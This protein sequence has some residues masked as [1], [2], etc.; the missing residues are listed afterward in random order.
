MRTD[1]LKISF[2]C[3]RENYIIAKFHQGIASEE[4][5]TEAKMLRTKID[6]AIINNLVGT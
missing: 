4:E 2:W 3:I 1:P 6:D 5:I